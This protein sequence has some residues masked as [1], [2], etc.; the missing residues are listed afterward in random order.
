M[1]KFTEKLNHDIVLSLNRVKRTF[2]RKIVHRG[3]LLPENIASYSVKTEDYVLELEGS[4]F[5]FHILSSRLFASSSVCKFVRN[6][7]KISCKLVQ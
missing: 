4:T 7:L 6:Y 1:Y 2:K 3:T 5:S